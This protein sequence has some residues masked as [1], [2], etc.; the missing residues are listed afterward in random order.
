MRK[1]IFYIIDNHDKDNKLN[2]LYTFAMMLVIIASLIPLA[3][4][5][6]PPLFKTIDNIA[7]IIFIID[8]ILR[9]ATADIKYHKKSL[10]SFIRYPFSPMAIVDLLSILPSISFLNNSFR[11]LRVIRMERAFK[12]LRVFR[13]L[14]YSK[15]FERIANV[16]KESQESLTAVCTLA[17][18]Y[19]LISALVIFNV[20]P[21][22]F[23]TFFD[24][25]YWATVSPT[26]VGYGDLY[27][28]SIAG[29]T[30]A[31]LSSFFGIAIVAL[32]AGIITAGYMT[33]LNREEEEEQKEDKK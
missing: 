1:K 2:R 25:V 29:R 33:E 23:K 31:M 16:I 12:I 28:T 9:W 24:A 15:S 3:F 7:V 10:W 20:E 4:K 8:Y 27:P 13:A 6:E 26:T 18:G 17:V 22:S 14:R 30:I 19:I 21:E 32:P 5:E 11:A